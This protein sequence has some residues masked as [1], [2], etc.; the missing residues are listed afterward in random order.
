MT[1]K[2]VL[3]RLQRL[4]IT[5]DLAM[6]VFDSLLAFELDN[7][8]SR[9]GV[10]RWGGWQSQ[11]RMGHFFHQR[12]HDELNVNDASAVCQLSSWPDSIQR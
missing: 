10:V 5:S 6:Q 3:P 4:N 1:A 7:T 12:E 8:Q 2:A 9:Q 11:W